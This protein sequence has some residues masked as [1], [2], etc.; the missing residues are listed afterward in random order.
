MPDVEIQEAVKSA[1]SLFYEKAL[2]Q[3]EGEWVGAIAAILQP[4]GMDSSASA[5]D[6]NYGEI[7]IRD[8][9]PVMVYLLTQGKYST[10]RHFLEVCLRLQSDQPQTR[11][12]FPTS[13]VEVDGKLVAD[14]GQRAIGRVVSVDATLWWVI[15]A[16]AYVQKSGDRAFASQPSIQAG[17]QR[18]LGLILPPSFREAPTLHVPDGAFMIDRPLDVWGAPLEIQVLLHGALLSA[19][20]LMKMAIESPD[21]EYL[22]DRIQQTVDH[23]RRLHRYL[24]KHYWVTGQKIQVMRRY[25]TEQYG[26]A[27]ENEHNIQVETIPDWL[28]QWLGDR[29][30]YLI[31]N[32][33]T[34][35]P[36][37]RFFTLGN[38]LGAIFDVLDCDQQS[39]LFGLVVQNQEELIAQMPLRICHPPIDGADWQIKTGY[40]RK[41]SPGCYHNGGHWPCLTWFLA[42][43]ILRQ[44]SSG[45]THDSAFAAEMNLLE[46]SYQ[47]MLSQLP[48]Q[49]WA[50]Y[51]DGS[52]AAW[53]G[54]QARLYQTWTIVGFL[55]MHHLLKVNPADAA[56]LN[57]PRLQDFC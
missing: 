54:Q 7:F 12:I 2:V 17:I 36:D 29:G 35:K 52:T 11:G 44:P 55:L 34:G 39:E 6:L 38:C 18:F 30:G 46:L 47:K 31:G 3:F 51:F 56:I 48:Q 1:R 22:G 24:Q 40:D 16:H 14:Y 37:F 33:R 32:M 41:N 13:F 10:V 45:S 9:V 21:F 25:P 23:A 19:A 53:V 43:A 20:G 5:P 49:N 57:V 15:L 26:E 27:I 50:E 42:A 4:V 8:N 28:Q